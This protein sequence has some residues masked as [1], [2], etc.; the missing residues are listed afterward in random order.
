LARLSATGAISAYSRTNE[1]EACEKIISQNPSR[2]LRSFGSATNIKL[3]PKNK[4]FQ[5][6]FLLPKISILGLR[7]KN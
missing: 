1:K 3:T 4:D 2:S 6:I 7:H 5:K